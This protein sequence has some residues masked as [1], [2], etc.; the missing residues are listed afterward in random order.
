MKLIDTSVL[1]EF[2]TGGEET[3][4]R[5]DAFFRELERQK[6][7]LLLTEETVIEIVY[8]L[9]KILGW[10]KEVVADVLSTVMADSL[11]KV[12]SRDVLMKAVRIYSSSKLDFIDCLKIARASKRKINEVLSF[13]KIL[14]KGGIKVIRP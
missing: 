9:E 14:E 11:F 4:D 6:E 10:E 3:V 1:I 12:E 13:R 2:F 8:Y 7:K 5:I